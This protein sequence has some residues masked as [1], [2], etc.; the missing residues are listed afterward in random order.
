MRL[1]FDR[2]ARDDLDRIFTWIAKDNPRA[3]RALV[4]R[5]EAKLNRLTTPELVHMGRPGLVEGTREP[6]DHPSIVACK[7]FE[8]IPDIVLLSVVHGAQRAWRRDG[9]A[10]APSL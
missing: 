9:P 8:D 2:A 7:V 3:A 5:I 1:T 6:L 4:D 10:A